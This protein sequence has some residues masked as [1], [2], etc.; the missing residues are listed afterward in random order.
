M[1]IIG[2]DLITLPIKL[3]HLTSTLKL[4]LLQMITITCFSI[5]YVVSSIHDKLLIDKFDDFKIPYNLEKL[6]KL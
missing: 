1:E 2:S 4:F 3:C 5:F 6:N